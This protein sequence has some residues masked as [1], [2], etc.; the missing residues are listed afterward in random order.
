M[1]NMSTCL[2]LLSICFY[3]SGQLC[4][5]AFGEFPYVFFNATFTFETVLASIKISESFEHCSR[6]VLKLSQ[7]PVPSLLADAAVSF[8]RT[9]VKS[10]SAGDRCDFRAQN[11]PE[12]V[13]VQA[14]GSIRRPQTHASFQR[15]ASQQRRGGGGRSERE[16]KEMKCSPTSFCTII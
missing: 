10:V 12:C 6:A 15:T 4:W 3:I 16:R 11:T 5:L 2:R 8:L 9:S 1:P 14:S 7:N 13:R